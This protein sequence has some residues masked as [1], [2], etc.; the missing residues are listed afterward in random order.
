M[1]FLIFLWTNINPFNT[2]EKLLMIAFCILCCLKTLLRVI[3]LKSFFFGSRARRRTPS[4]PH[5]LSHP[6]PSSQTPCPKTLEKPSPHI[7]TLTSF[8][9]P[10]YIWESSILCLRISKSTSH[11]CAPF[12]FPSARNQTSFPLHKVKRIPWSN[13]NIGWNRV[14][15]SIF[16]SM[17]N[18][19]NVKMT[20]SESWY[21][22]FWWCIGFWAGRRDP[23]TFE[24]QSAFLMM[25][26][27]RFIP[28]LRQQHFY[29]FV[30]SS[31]PFL[32]LCNKNHLCIW[33][34]IFPSFPLWGNL[35]CH[36]EFSF[37]FSFKLLVIAFESD[38]FQ[39]FKHLRPG[40]ASK[41][42]LD[43]NQWGKMG[44]NSS[45]GPITCRFADFTI[46]NR[47]RWSRARLQL[48]FLANSWN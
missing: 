37:I 2:P 7:H 21:K 43:G 47:G 45:R 13:W 38:W 6:F 22:L 33:K 26:H 46:F 27:S 32:L 4:I 24:S 44:E 16:A 18:L 29:S 19:R 5:F 41:R 40:I 3:K 12:F 23:A 20:M 31:L 28:L 48:G 42:R 34:S 8:K 14:P 1:D 35:L 9:S 36:V 17:K 10:E 39:Y 11:E 30:F 25:T 15:I